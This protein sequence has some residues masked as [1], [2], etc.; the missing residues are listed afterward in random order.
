M[1]VQTVRVK[2]IRC[3]GKGY[4]VDTSRSKNSMDEDIGRCGNCHGSG[5]VLQ[6]G[7]VTNGKG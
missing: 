3:E 1:K 2:C 7:V 4:I 5:V 6:D